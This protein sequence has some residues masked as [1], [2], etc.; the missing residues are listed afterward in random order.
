MRLNRDGKMVLDTYGRSTGFCI[1][2]IEKKPLSHFL[3]GT[4]VLSFGTAGCNLGCKFCQNWDISKSREVARLSDSASPQAIAA[5]AQQHG[6]RSV[7]FTYNDPVIWAEYAIDTATACREQGIKSVAV[8]AGYITPEAR[9][10]FF[11]AMDAANIDLKGFT[12]EFYYRTTGAHLD[13]ILDSIRFACRETDCWIELTNLIIPDANEDRDQ[14][15]Q[16]C[17]WIVDA[18]GADVPIHFTAFHPDFRMKDRGR[19]EH[20]TLIDA[21]EIACRAG[22]R[23]VYVGNVHDVARQ[24]TYCPGCGKLLIERDWHQLGRYELN[25]NRCRYCQFEIAGVFESQPGRWGQR[26]QPVRIGGSPSPTASSSGGAPTEAS[27]SAAGG[28]SRNA[29]RIRTGQSQ[30]PRSALP[31]ARPSPTESTMDE[32]T[33]TLTLEFNAEQRRR[34]H[35]AACQ[36]VFDTA[37]CSVSKRAEETLGEVEEL[38]GEIAHVMIAGLYVT[39]KRGQTLRGCCGFQGR[40]VTLASGLIDAATRSTREDPR[41][42]PISPVELAHLHVSVSILGPPRLIEIS[43]EA[44]ADAVR[45]GKHG[46]RIQ[47][48]D[49]AGLLLPSAFGQSHDSPFRWRGFR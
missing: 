22:L 4:A 2:P 10:E 39:L 26:R 1:D 35:Q 31:S 34:I 40:S 3:P 7:A 48:G 33:A 11:H 25:D 15:R 5:A 37:C 41:M 6:C 28:G 42:P 12:E 14:L 19:T 46:L 38:L 36:I 30:S 43:G 20:A 29:N 45:V 18:A 9:G 47:M 32:N 23:Y 27:S 44:R 16:M 13:P 17:D 49:R 24:S 21:Y 8:T